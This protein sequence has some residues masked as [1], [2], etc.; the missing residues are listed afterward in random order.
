[1]PKAVDDPYWVKAY[2]RRIRA[3]ERAL[4]RVEELAY[5]ITDP[6]IGCHRPGIGEILQTIDRALRP[7]K[8]GKR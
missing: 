8:G 3:L 1:M 6:D 5:K 4:R 2:Q 7:A